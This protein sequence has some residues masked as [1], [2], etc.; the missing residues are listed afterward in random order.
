MVRSATAT[1]QGQ[2]PEPLAAVVIGGVLHQVPASRVEIETEIE[3]GV[4]LQ[5]E[6]KEL[7]QRRN[8][9]GEATESLIAAYHA[10]INKLQEE[11]RLERG[12]VEAQIAT[13]QAELEQ[14]KARLYELIE[15]RMG[16]QK[17][18]KVTG[19]AGSIEVIRTPKI[20]VPPENIPALRK[21]L[22][23]A[24]TTAFEVTEKA[25]ALSPAF[26]LLKTLKGT[27]LAKFQQLV[28]AT[29]SGRVRFLGK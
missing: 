9:I 24:F 16:E 27:K 7:E 5:A 17:S 19:L 26:T 4:K 13:K 1:G 3:K 25:K 12:P 14:V 10:E 15:P 8:S 22:G 23:D 18:M 2:A 28:K 11:L 29:T 6:I 21:L 20:E